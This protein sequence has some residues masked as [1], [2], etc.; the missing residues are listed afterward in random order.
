MGAIF[1]WVIVFVLAIVT[2]LMMTS[3]IVV[4]ILL[5]IFIA[6]IVSAVILAMRADIP[7]N[8]GHSTYRR[9]R[10][11]KSRTSKSFLKMILDGQARTQ[12]RNGSH[13]GVMCGPGGSRRNKRRRY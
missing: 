6:G 5:L 9:R 7:A 2:A 8:V 10:S 11:Y 1:T 12:K 3:P 13:R 4:L